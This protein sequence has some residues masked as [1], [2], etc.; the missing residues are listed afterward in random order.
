LDIKMTGCLVAVVPA[1]CQPFTEEFFKQ[2]R[3]LDE[4]E[5]SLGALSEYEARHG[6]SRGIAILRA[7]LKGRAEKLEIELKDRLGGIVECTRREAGD[8]AVD[9]VV[10]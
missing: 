9:E 5:D 7:D 8:I 3:T 1:A 4:V 10:G 6:T 2:L